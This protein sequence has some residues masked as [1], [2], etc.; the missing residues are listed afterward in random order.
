MCTKASWMCW[1]VLVLGSAERASKS[2]PMVAV[3]WLSSEGIRSTSAATAPYSPCRSFSQSCLAFSLSCAAGA[4]AARRERR[5]RVQ[6]ARVYRG[7]GALEKIDAGGLEARMA[8]GV[9]QGLLDHGHLL[10]PAVEGQRR[11]GE[12]GHQG[13]GQQR[14]DGSSR[15]VSAGRQQQLV[16]LADAERLPAAQSVLGAAQQGRGVR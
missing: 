14:A 9:E 16:K 8:C 5:H 10:G 3:S 4:A 1:R 12:R 6:T 2:A 13:D 11:G 7:E 15:R